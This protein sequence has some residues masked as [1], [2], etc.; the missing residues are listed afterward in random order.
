[1]RKRYLVF[2][3]LLV[4]LTTVAGCSPTNVSS[5]EEASFATSQLPDYARLI[6]LTTFGIVFLDIGFCDISVTEKA[7]C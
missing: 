5:P 6:S 7:N 2:V 4:V 3:L 1:M